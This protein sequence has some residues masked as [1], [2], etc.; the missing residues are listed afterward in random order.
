MISTIPGHYSK[1]IFMRKSCLASLIAEQIGV[2]NGHNGIFC[3]EELKFGIVMEEAMKGKT[4][5]RAKY[6]RSGEI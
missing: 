3:D 5:Y 4:G 6:H 1:P 2:T